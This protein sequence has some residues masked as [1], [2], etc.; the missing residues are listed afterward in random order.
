M[1]HGE[2]DRAHS[3]GPGSIGCLTC[4]PRHSAIGHR[5]LDFPFPEEVVSWIVATPSRALS[6][7]I[8]VD[9]PL[10]LLHPGLIFLASRGFHSSRGFTSATI[11][12]L[13][14]LP[15]TSAPHHRLHP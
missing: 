12:Y 8:L 2:W 4:L 9:L 6:L 15:P 10:Q 11:G 7:S 13:Y 3:D 5:S 1:Q 14:P